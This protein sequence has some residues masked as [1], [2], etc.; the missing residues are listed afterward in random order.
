MQFYQCLP[1]NIDA[2]SS[3]KLNI[4]LLISAADLAAEVTQ[5]VQQASQGT[6][7][8]NRADAVQNALMRSVWLDS[9]PCDYNGNADFGKGFDSC[10]CKTLKQQV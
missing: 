6:N 3:A 8:E 2:E 7:S 9:L 1:E 10:S 4:A 5:L